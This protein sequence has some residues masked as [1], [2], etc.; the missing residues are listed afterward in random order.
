M[1]WLCLILFLA[2]GGAISGDSSLL[3]AICKIVLT[4]GSAIFVLWLFSLN[5]YISIVVIIIGIL[6]FV[7]YLKLSPTKDNRTTNN[8][9]TPCETENFDEDLNKNETNYSDFQ[10][11]LQAQ[12]KTPIQINNEKKEK[13]RNNAIS[14]ANSTYIFIKKGCLE[15]AKN[16]KYSVY[17]GG[18]KVIF[19]YIYKRLPEF[20][21]CERKVVYINTVKKHLVRHLCVVLTVNLRIARKPCLNDITDVVVFHQNTVFIGINRSFGTRSD[22]RHLAF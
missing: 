16:G 9:S 10:K 22:K 8:F 2:F 7:L 11:E 21:G 13:T 18:K 19:D 1:I 3:K 4:G 6:I 14:C 20:I 12:M 17:N 15:Q 5:V